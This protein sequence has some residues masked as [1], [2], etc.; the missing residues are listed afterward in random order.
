MSS[1][2]SSSPYK[3]SRDEFEIESS[4]VKRSQ[5]HQIH[6]EVHLATVSLMMEALRKQQAF[7]KIEEV[8]PEP[9]LRCTQKPYWP[10]ITRAR[11]M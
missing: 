11:L 3:R 10:M 2:Y 6:S 7:P 8:A 1:P 5:H 9:E 4:P